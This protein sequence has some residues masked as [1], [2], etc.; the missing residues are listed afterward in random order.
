MQQ[1]IAYEWNFASHILF[2]ISECNRREKKV[3]AWTVNDAKSMQRMLSERVDGIVTSDPTLLRQLMQRIR[4]QCF[5]DDFSLQAWSVVWGF[6]PAEETWFYFSPNI[7]LHIF[8]DHKYLL[9]LEWLIPTF[10]F[11]DYNEGP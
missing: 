10:F 5:E 7:E 3:Y 8:S 9:L 2:V 11:S 4:L 6:L 1:Y